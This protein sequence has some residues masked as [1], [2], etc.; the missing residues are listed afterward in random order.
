MRQGLSG[1]RDQA[2][3]DA[4]GNAASQ[5]GISCFDNGGLNRGFLSHFVIQRVF[6]M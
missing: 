1:L 3:G 6:N 5:L 4:T 2:W